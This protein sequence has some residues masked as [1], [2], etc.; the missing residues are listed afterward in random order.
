[1][2][3]H[4]PRKST[5]PA[6]TGVSTEHIL[7]QSS[8]A[9]ALS[10]TTLY[11][12]S[13][14]ASKR[15]YNAGYSAACHDLLNMIQQG[16]STDSDPSREVTI[17]RIM[18]YIEARLEAIKAREEEEDEEEE[19]AAKGVAVPK[20]KPSSPTLPPAPPTRREQV[21]GMSLP[22]IT[23]S[24]TMRYSHR[25]SLLPRLHIRLH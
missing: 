10:L 12:S 18:D 4:R 23:D 20:T 19:R 21:R 9:A 8:A 6:P 25:P 7:T 5:I 11:R 24:L 15:A 13:K 14:T 22:L 16:V 17:G 3:V 1:M 2:V